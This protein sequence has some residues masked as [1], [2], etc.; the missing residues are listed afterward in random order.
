MTFKPFPLIVLQFLRWSQLSFE[1]LYHSYVTCCINI[2][3]C[4]WECWSWGLCCLRHR[5]EELR[6][7]WDHGF[8]SHWEHGCLSLVFLMC[9]V[10]SGLCNKLITCSEESYWVRVCVCLILCNLETSTVKQPRPKLGCCT[11]KKIMGLGWAPLI[12]QLFVLVL[13]DI[14][15][16]CR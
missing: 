16:Y 11:K 3:Y 1:I 8:R 15:G 9:C 4:M 6:V 14:M 12:M 2:C 10:S 5:S 7:C 13:T